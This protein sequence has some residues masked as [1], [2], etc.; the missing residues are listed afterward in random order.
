MIK[1]SITVVYILSY[2][3]G[4]LLRPHLAP[5][6]ICS[7]LNASRSLHSESPKMYTA[8]AEFPQTVLFRAYDVTPMVKQKYPDRLKIDV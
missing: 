1:C 6:L 2:R 4:E 5:G 3:G 8:K 7:K